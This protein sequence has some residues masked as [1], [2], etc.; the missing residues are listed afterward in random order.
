MT[1]AVM[2]RAVTSTFSVSR[3]A[4]ELDS[5]MGCTRPDLS[6]QTLENGPRDDPTFSSHGH[7][8]PT[9]GGNALHPSAETLNPA[10]SVAS[11]RAILSSSCLLPRGDG[12][13]TCA[14]QT[15]CL[16]LSRTK[17]TA[18]RALRVS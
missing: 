7:G 12:V 3:I 5:G 15:P 17:F 8:V 6:G 18:L 13:P 2:D 10:T 14:E 9:V 11:P 4:T 1:P 16:V